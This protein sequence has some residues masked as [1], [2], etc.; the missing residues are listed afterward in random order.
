MGEITE[1]LRRARE[2]AQGPGP[3]RP[4]PPG[5]PEPVPVA[6]HK[7]RRPEV[8]ISSEPRGFWE[9]RATLVKGL[10][11]AD[12]WRQIAL[13]VRRAM[14]RRSAR[15][16]IVTSAMRAEGKSVVACNLSLALATVAAGR[17]V[18]LVDLDLRR[19]SVADG[20]CLKPDCGIEEVLAERA[21]LADACIPTDVADL[22]VYPAAAPVSD[23]H[24]LLSRDALPRL[25]RALAGEYALI[26]ADAPPVLPVPDVP[27]IAPHMDACLAVTRAGITR[28][29][30]FR[31]ML[32]LLPE[33][34]L[35]GTILNDV[36]LRR[37]G[38]YDYEGYG[39]T[40]DER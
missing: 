34:K 28:Q 23:A 18:A 20:L 24:R 5:A 10:A 13:Q 32:A 9:A 14:D 39:P 25:L 22:D 4:S 33:D 35:L 15:S 27:L 11:V 12:R 19:P 17:R 36:H 21:S 1:A 6:V 8:S 30:R 29:A 26:V 31:E 40:G 37:E 2:A 16:L 7:P 38:S 3:E